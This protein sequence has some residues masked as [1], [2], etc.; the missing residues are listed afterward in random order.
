MYV[1]QDW[2]DLE[3][4]EILETLSI[5][6]TRDLLVG[7]TISSAT[8]AA[9]VIKTLVG[10]TVDGTPQSRVGGASPSSTIDPV[11]GATRSYVSFPVSRCVAGNRYL[12]DVLATFS[13]GRTPARFSHVWCKAPS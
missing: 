8:V 7:E 12:F 1:G 9:S 10:A 11:T 6:F 13:S 2:D 3:P 4:S 5:E